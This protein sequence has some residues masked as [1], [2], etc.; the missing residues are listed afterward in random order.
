MKF[1]YIQSANQQI[2]IYVNSHME[3]PML[4]CWVKIVCCTERSLC[5]A[6][7]IK[8]WAPLHFGFS[9]E[10]QLVKVVSF[11]LYEYLLAVETF[12]QYE[13]LL[14]MFLL[15]LLWLFRSPPTIWGAWKLIRCGAE[16]ILGVPFNI[17]WA[18]KITHMRWTTLI[19]Q[20]SRKIHTQVAMEKIIHYNGKHIILCVKCLQNN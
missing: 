15:F 14:L 12:N 1:P 9:Q 3:L 7:F 4:V 16:T 11:I 10:L 5:T 17:C 19:K 6:S 2:L 8:H 18:A 20:S 13:L